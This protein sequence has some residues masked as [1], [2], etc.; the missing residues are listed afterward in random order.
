M[1]PEAVYTRNERCMCALQLLKFQVIRR[2]PWV[3]ECMK[4][5]QPLPPMPL[6]GGNDLGRP[7]LRSTSLTGTA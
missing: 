5:I 1:D 3:S 7:M 4:K 2:T 6:E